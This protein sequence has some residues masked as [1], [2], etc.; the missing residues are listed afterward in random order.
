MLSHVY[1]RFAVSLFAFALMTSDLCNCAQ[2]QRTLKAKLERKGYTKKGNY[3]N[4]LLRSQKWTELVF[5]RVETSQDQA[6]DWWQPE[7]LKGLRRERDF[8]GHAAKSQRFVSEIVNNLEKLKNRKLEDAVGWKGSSFQLK[9]EDYTWCVQITLNR[10]H[11]KDIF[12]ILLLLLLLFFF[13]VMN[14]LSNVPH[15]FGNKC[16]LFWSSSFE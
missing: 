10:L 8:S 16:L 14:F 6:W 5:S 1:L 11:A 7:I 13:A 15:S 9:R 2:N 12:R 3:R 4:K